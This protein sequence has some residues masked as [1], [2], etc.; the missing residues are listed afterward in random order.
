MK[1]KVF[2]VLD[3]GIVASERECCSAALQKLVDEVSASGGGEIHFPQGRYT[4][5]TVFL[6]SNVAI[7]LDG[8]TLLGSLR[9]EDYRKDEEVDYPLYQDASHS[10]FH[11][12][13]L[14][15]EGCEN[16]SITGNGRVDMRSVW[17]EKNVRNMCHR[18]AKAIAFKE[19]RNVK[20][21][22]ICVQNA[23]DLAIY[24]AGCRDVLVQKVRARAYI[25]G[26][27]PDGC[28]NVTIADCEVETGD[29]G[30]VLKASY[31][32]N[33]LSA[34]E[35]ITVRDCS[36]KS[37]CNAVKFG[38]ET[39]GDFKNITVENVR[40]CNTRLSGIAVESVDGGHIDGVTFRNIQMKN[41]GTPIFVH[42]GKRLRGPKGTTIGSIS[43]V[44]FENIEATG[45]YRP[46][47]AIAWNYASFV[48]G[49]CY[50]EPWNIGVA[51]GLE[52]TQTFT[53]QSPW[54]I[55]SNVCGLQG[56]RIQNI[57]F[58]DVRLQLNGGATA[59]ENAV[60]EE[61]LSYPEA[62]VYGRI[63]PAKGIYFRHIDGLTLDNVQVE[64]IYADA[65]KAFTFDDT[66]NLVKER[67]SYD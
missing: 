50:Q 35:N 58:K 38:T 16:I 28:Q 8:A 62:F 14:V 44:S 41:V 36:I 30:I 4:L 17:D 23:T 59:Y 2:S 45:E 25:D 12:S 42:L 19:C 64:T 61:P 18:G 60:P 27:S 11:C 52:E 20:I 22:G 29:D 43:N 48:A 53:E 54:Q 9:F 39:N 1:S 21:E 5:G 26:I 47:E 51:E 40:I 49:D 32:L 6:R 67:G 63:L 56:H 37:R 31:T 46:Y 15:A 55:T 10:F 65:R 33:R 57:R 7:V 3:Y 24:F 34:C 13:M 66:L